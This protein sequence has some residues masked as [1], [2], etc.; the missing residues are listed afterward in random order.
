MIFSNGCD[1]VFESLYLNEDLTP[2]ASK[3]S[4]IV[5]PETDAYLNRTI[6]ISMPTDP[7][8]IKD[9]SK[10]NKVISRYKCDYALYQPYDESKSL[11]VAAFKESN[12]LYS[13]R[14]FKTL[15]C[16]Y[17]NGRLHVIRGKF[18]DTDVGEDKTFLGYL[19]KILSMNLNTYVSA[20]LCMAPFDSF[21]YAKVLPDPEQDRKLAEFIVDRFKL[22]PEIITNLHVAKIEPARIL[23]FKDQATRSNGIELVQWN[24]PDPSGDVLCTK[25]KDSSTSVIILEIKDGS[26]Y[27]VY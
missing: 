19:N 24:F 10:F 17:L 26:N 18:S 27:L 3:A 7:E 21:A 23:T 8:L 5:N 16:Y 11:R 14:N 20:C 6:I 12:N 13:V 25:L 4:I 9:L 1:S 15:P 22:T 2:Y